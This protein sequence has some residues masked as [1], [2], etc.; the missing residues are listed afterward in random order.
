MITFLSKKII[1]FLDPFLCKSVQ[2]K[3]P[4]KLSVN[5]DH[6]YC[7]YI[8]IIHGK[9]QK[10]YQGQGCNMVSR[11]ENKRHETSPYLKLT[12]EVISHLMEKIESS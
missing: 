4:D 3:T 2:P 12:F 7:I 9:L 5:V 11:S 6:V 10:S 1:I 8:K